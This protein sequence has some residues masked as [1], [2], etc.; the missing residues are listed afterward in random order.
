M[1]TLDKARVAPVPLFDRL[2]DLE[3][4]MP[5]EARPHR[6]LDEEGLLASVRKEAERLLE[7]RCALPLAEEE[8][9]R[10]EARSAVDYGLPDLLTLY[11]G[12]SESRERLAE[13]L[14]RALSAFEPRL[15]EIRVSVERFSTGERRVEATVHAL[16]VKGRLTEPVSFP[17]AAGGTDGR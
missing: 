7:V 11:P 2:V 15:R 3:P 12:E 1:G 4:W 8:A 6:T 10:P 17:I 9:L 14:A 13:V 16:L 5:R